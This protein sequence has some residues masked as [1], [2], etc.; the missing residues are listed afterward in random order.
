M[1]RCG[2]WFDRYP[3]DQYDRYWIA[4]SSSALQNITSNS[5]LDSGY[6]V[7]KPPATVMRTAVSNLATE[8]DPYI[9]YTVTPFT[10]QNNSLLI[11]F[12]LAELQVQVLHIAHLSTYFFSAHCSSFKMCY[13]VLNMQCT[14]FAWLLTKDN[15]TCSPARF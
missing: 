6:A 8:P 14:S 13:A 12:F 2:P 4:E 3:D 9:Q 1:I 15:F 5:V 11:N 10:G 7:D